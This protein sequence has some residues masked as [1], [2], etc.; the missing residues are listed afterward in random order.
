MALALRRELDKAGFTHT[1][2]HMADA[3]LHVPRHRSRKTS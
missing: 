2:I 3:S 1:K